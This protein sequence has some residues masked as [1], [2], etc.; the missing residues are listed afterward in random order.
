MRILML[1]KFLYPN[2]GSE[3]YIFKLGKGEQIPIFVSEKFKNCF[4]EHKLT[5]IDFLEIKV[6]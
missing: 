2:G 5:G 4:E 1:N 6:V 3:T